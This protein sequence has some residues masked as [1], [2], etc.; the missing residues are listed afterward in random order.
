VSTLSRLFALPRRELAALLA[1]FVLSLPAVTPRIYSSDEIE[2]FSYL[3]SIW[4][5]HDV[6]FEN[7][8]QYF[9]HRGIA[10]S[11][12]FHE[13]FLARETEAGRRP[14]FGT[15]GCAL[16]WAP[17]YAAGD[18][19]ARAMRAAGH[20]VA[21][22]GL[23]QPYIAAVAYGSAV[24]GFLAL[25]LSIGFAR[26]TLGVSGT[27]RAPLVAGVLVWIGTPLL[28]YMYIA[29]PMSHACSAF[30]VALFLTVWLHARQTW[31]PG[32]CA[33]LGAAA[34]LMAMT[35]EQDA[36]VAA[37]PALDFV[38]TWL[39]RARRDPDAH[40]AMLRAAVAGCAATVLGLVPQLVAYWRLNGH[41][42]PSRLV[43]RKMSWS[44]PHAVEVLFSPAHGFL[45][46]TPL[47]ILALA[48]L[49]VL[50]AS[51]A[52]DTRRIALAA[53]VIAA[54]QVYVG[55]SVES[56][57]VAGAF[58]QRRFVA[59]TCILVLGLAGLCSA[60]RS[61]LPRAAVGVLAALC[62]WWNLGLIALFGTG[63]MDRQRLELARNAHDVFVTIP[64]E[65]PALAWRYLTNRES[66]YGRPPRQAP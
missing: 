37:G 50:A 13:T 23:S 65:A 10:R 14:N 15:L 42:T 63:G 60:S 11:D 66:Y 24:Y 43:I 31:S 53:L 28:F 6:S 46:W 54:L 33:A 27:A 2:Y 47:A 8:Y 52:S 4:F 45:A 19:A 21:V 55:G 16:L 44:A 1:L 56:W 29:P 38:V 36:F 32:R 40:A 34:A 20:D 39:Q 5:D 7:E 12:G 61:G 48:G 30:A 57:T 41:P 25:L 58:G 17:F 35:R 22:D 62:V 49:I 51:R 26:R 18:L 3:R 9:Y 59:L 64:R